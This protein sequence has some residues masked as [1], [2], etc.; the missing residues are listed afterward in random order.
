LVTLVN[1]ACV[2]AVS[3]SFVSK[4]Q[5][6]DASGALQTNHEAIA[7]NKNAREALERKLMPQD[8]AN[9]RWKRKGAW[10]YQSWNK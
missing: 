4:N 8:A 5:R 10:K 9:K 7:E 1:A 3:R 6:G 2:A